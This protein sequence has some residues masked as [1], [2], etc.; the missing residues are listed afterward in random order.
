MK[1]RPF[2][3]GFTLLACST[4][5]SSPASSSHEGQAIST[6]RVPIHYVIEGNGPAVVLSHCLACNLHYWDGAAAEL[7]RDHRVIRLDLAGHGASG[8]ERTKWNIDA[9]VGDIRAVVNAANV[10]RFTL[11]GHSISGTIALETARQLGD[12]VAGVVPV[13]S[14]IDV[15][16]HLPDET[17]A[18]IVAEMRTSYRENI[19]RQLPHLLPNGAD[20]KVVA[21]VSA[22]AMSATPDRS[23]S[24]LDAVFAYREDLTLHRLTMP[25]IAIDSDRRPVAIEHNRAHAPQFE[26]RIIP[27]SSHW[28]MLDRPAEFARTLRDVVV[29]IESGRAKRR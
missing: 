28:L 14:V 9:F 24:I 15:D 6:D 3:L 19:E 22:D 2:T 29:A 11:V 4:G 17:R 21:R 16:A 13:D 5:A 25:I 26:A 12:R 8:S 23:A 27:E 7:A 20:P 10:E 18:Q 1:V